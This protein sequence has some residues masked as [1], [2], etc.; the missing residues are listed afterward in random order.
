MGGFFQDVA[1]NVVAAIIVVVGGL[2]GAAL[3]KRF[4]PQWLGW[5]WAEIVPYSVQLSAALLVIYVAFAFL[6]GGPETNP[7]EISAA[8]QIVPQEKAAPTTEELVSKWVREAGYSVVPLTL[9]D[10][11]NYLFHINFMY[12][13]HTINLKQKK[14]TPH[15]IEIAVL[16]PMQEGQ[17]KWWNGLKPEQR[18]DILRE[19]YLSLGFDAAFALDAVNVNMGGSPTYGF[20][21]IRI[22]VVDQYLTRGKFM[23]EIESAAKYQRMVKAGFDDLF[24]RVT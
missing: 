3:L 7:P 17:A 10:D 19:L 18:D 24:E 8:P 1:A 23:L 4:K 13:A 20:S 21:I 6:L 12:G 11:N 2:V 16:Q 9:G 22:A 5:Q 14:K 15:L